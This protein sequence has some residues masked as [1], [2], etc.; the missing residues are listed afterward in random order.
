MSLDDTMVALRVF[1]AE[2]R[3]LTDTLAASMGALRRHH[4]QV[5]AVWNDDFA[6]RYQH[7]WDSFEHHLDDYLRR[8]APRYQQFLET[9]TAALGRYLGD[10]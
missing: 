1:E 2:V 7:R 5:A 4:E 8:D 6:R 9:R 10:D 3:E